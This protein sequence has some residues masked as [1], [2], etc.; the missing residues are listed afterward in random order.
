[1]IF[2]PRRLKPNVICKPLP[3]SK[4]MTHYHNDVLKYCAAKN[5]HSPE[6]TFFKFL[7]FLKCLRIVEARL[8]MPENQKNIIV[9]KLSFQRLRLLQFAEVNNYG[10]KHISKKTFVVHMDSFSSYSVYDL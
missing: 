5:R 10:C 9:Y 2:H 4:P 3:D 8:K 1:M 6:R 7:Y